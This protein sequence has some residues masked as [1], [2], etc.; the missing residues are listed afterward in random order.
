V[1]VAVVTYAAMPLLQ[2]I[3]LARFGGTLDLSGAGAWL[4]VL[5]LL[6]ILFLGAYGIRRTWLTGEE[7]VLG[8]LTAPR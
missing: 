2:L 7:P 4:Y 1:R 5:F 3:A 8:V 6:S